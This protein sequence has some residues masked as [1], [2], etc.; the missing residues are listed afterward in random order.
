LTT[1]YYDVKTSMTGYDF[2][3]NKTLEIPYEKG[4]E[5]D[6]TEYYDYIYIKMQVE[7]KKSKELPRNSFDD[8]RQAFI[9]TK[10]I[11]PVPRLRRE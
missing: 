4:V 2:K 11:F 7:T 6:R 9:K 5:T 10:K 1:Y 8:T 3:G